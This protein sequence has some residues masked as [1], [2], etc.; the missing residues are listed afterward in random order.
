MTEAAM[1]QQDTSTV[2]MDLSRYELNVG[3]YWRILVKRRIFILVTFISVLAGTI[4]YTNSLPLIYQAVARVKISH[5][6]NQG[7]LGL[8]QNFYFPSG[9]DPMAYYENVIVSQAVMERVVLRLGLLN[10]Q[11][12][13]EA[14]IEK[15]EEI[16]ASISPRTDADTEMIDIEVNHSDPVLCAAIANVT[17]QVFS[18]VNLHDKTKQARSLRQFVE[19]QLG[20]FENNLKS[21]E[22]KIQSFRE[23]GRALGIAIGLESQLSQLE[24]DRAELLRRYTDKHPDVA[25]L[26]D[27][28]GSVRKRIQELPSNELELARLQRDLEINDRAYRTMKDKYESARLSEAE[29]VG[30]VSVVEQAG[31]PEVPIS[32]KKNLNKM[33]GALAGILLGVILAFGI[34]SLDTSIG[35]IEDVERAVRIP[36]VGVVPYFDPQAQDVPWWRID[37]IVLQMIKR[38]VGSAPN[39]ASLIMNQDTFSTLAEAYRILRT[40]IEFM[41]EKQPGDGGKVLVLTSTGPQEGKSLTSANLAISLAQA[42]KR[43]LLVDADL[44]RPVV[45][46]LFGIKRGPGL[47]D[48][49]MNM[50]SAN[51]IKCTMGDILIG[52][53]SN[54]DRVVATKMLDRLEVIPTGQTTENP[55]ELLASDLMKEF[56][57]E[58]RKKYDYIIL[59]TPPVLPVTDARTLGMLADVTFFIYRSGFT[60]RRSLVR[61]KDELDLAGVKVRGIILNHATP[62]VALSNR[63]YYRY[64]GER[65]QPKKQIRNL[66]PKKI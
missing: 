65:K 32:P 63:D 29:T 9:G 36:V 13:R 53:G 48:Y 52:E 26:N 64:Y 33:L 47:A 45:H 39:S 27:M 23:S 10:P 28:I 8:E 35:T 14:L 41:L 56:C 22:E 62:E 1:P 34:E 54:W 4:A 61:A 30:D 43:T 58:M 21:T 6:V 5:N 17:A 38:R 18:E 66:K 31:V 12:K 25:K 42:G 49:L 59:D 24:G 57:H 51:D 2:A 44:R 7:A 16:R 40:F 3:D 15:A 20:F 60:A 11:S 55:A 37:E 46:R 19:K 50:A